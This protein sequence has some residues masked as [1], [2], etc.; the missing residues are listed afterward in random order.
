MS[1]SFINLEDGRRLG[2][3]DC[4]EPEGLPIFLLH[5]TPGSRIFGFESEPFIHEER[6][7]IIT[8]ERPGYGLSDPCKDRTIKNFS[9]DIEALANHL[10]IRKFHIAGISGGGPYAL[11]CG[12]CLP[13]RVISVT[14][15]ASATP[16]DMEGFYEGMSR[17]NK[18]AFRISKHIPF[19]LRPLYFYMAHAFRK[20]PEKLIEAIKSQL[21]SWD[22][23]VLEQLKHKK[24]MNV[25]I[26]HVREAYRQG[27]EGAYSDTVLLSKPWGIDF[28]SITAPIFMW[29]GES[30]TLMPISPA[31]NFSRIL[32]EC[33][34][35]FIKEAGHLLLESEEIRAEIIGKIKG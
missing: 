3:I 21:C 8:P 25:F 12:Q 9:S 22:Q 24:V 11:V 5:G 19:L 16:T 27:M 15:I 29:H 30:D 7:R 32:P 34:S 17:G 33:E 4:G 31:K 13:E 20:N 18:L 2:F 14:L 1:D 35:H 23:E 6:L 10:G 26:S 28:K